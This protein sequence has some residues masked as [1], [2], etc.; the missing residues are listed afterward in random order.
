MGWYVSGFQPY[1]CIGCAVCPDSYPC[2]E[3]RDVTMPAG[4]IH[5]RHLRDLRLYF[6]EAFERL[7]RYEEE[8]QMTQMTQMEC[9]GC[10]ANEAWNAGD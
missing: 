6:L 2:V 7:R 5:L 9:R 10:T 4:C 1:K 8:P 3:S